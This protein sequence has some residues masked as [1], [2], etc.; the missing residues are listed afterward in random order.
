MLNKR[1]MSMASL[2]AVGLLGVSLSGCVVVP[3]RGYYGGGYADDSVV[4]SP[5][6]WV[7]GYWGWDGGRRRW[8]DGHYEHRDHGGRGDRGDRGDRGGRG[9][10]GDRGR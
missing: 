4:V 6:I 1:V 10:R 2:L 5:G 3:S 9:D 7:D 8:Y